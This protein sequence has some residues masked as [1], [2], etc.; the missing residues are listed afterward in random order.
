MGYAVAIHSS[1][2]F[3][4]FKILIPWGCVVL[5]FMAL[6]NSRR[7]ERSFWVSRRP[8]GACAVYCTLRFLADSFTKSDSS[9]T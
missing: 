8:A 2:G 1:E 4:R 5:G 3:R 6:T 9:S 7:E